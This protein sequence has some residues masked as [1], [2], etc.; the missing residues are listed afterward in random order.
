M[1][2]MTAQ[3]LS[4]YSHDWKVLPQTIVP[5]AATRAVHEAPSGMV[6]IPAGDFVF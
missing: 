5:I 1:K 2:Q 6:K 4:S 3:P